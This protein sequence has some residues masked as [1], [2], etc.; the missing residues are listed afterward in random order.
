MRTSFLQYSMQ[1]STSY[2]ILRQNHTKLRPY[3][4]AVQKI[5]HGFFDMDQLGKILEIQRKER[6]KISKT[7]KFKSDL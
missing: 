2:R 6:L 4:S 1:L 3:A 5:L 7:A